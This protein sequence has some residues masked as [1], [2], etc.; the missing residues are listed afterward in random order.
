MTG[1]VAKK[2]ASEKGVA[3]EKAIITGVEPAPVKK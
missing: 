2:K 1:L 3:E